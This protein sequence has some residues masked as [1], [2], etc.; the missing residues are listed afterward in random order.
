M[1]RVAKTIWSLT[2]RR[3]LTMASGLQMTKQRWLQ[4]RP[5]DV[6]MVV[7]IKP[8]KFLW[9]RKPPKFR[10]KI[11]ENTI[12]VYLKVDFNIQTL[13]S[14]S[15]QWKISLFKRIY[16]SN[17]CEASFPNMFKIDVIYIYG[18]I[19]QEKLIKDIKTHFG[20]IQSDPYYY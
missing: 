1:E 12:S 4:Q 8:G 19:Y 15:S 20:K 7:S 18:D 5:C 17:E 16:K 14:L 3:Q 9:N 6:N 11:I 13:D 2:H 10:K